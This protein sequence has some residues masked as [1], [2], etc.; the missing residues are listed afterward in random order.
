MYACKKATPISRQKNGIY[1]APT[2]GPKLAKDLAKIRNT[3]NIKCPTHM[4]THSL[5]AKLKILIKKVIT[6]IGIIKGMMK[7]GTPEGQKSRKNLSP[8][9]IAATINRVNITVPD[10]AM[11]VDR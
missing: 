1:K 4:F 6:S 3:F 8:C 10:I 7:T 2:K 9:L 11:L 5:I